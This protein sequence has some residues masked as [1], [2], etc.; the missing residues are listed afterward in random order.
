MNANPLTQAIES[1]V[2]DCNDLSCDGICNLGPIAG[3]DR[4]EWLARLKAQFIAHP[5]PT[6]TK[7]RPSQQPAVIRVRAQTGSLLTD[8]NRCG[9]PRWNGKACQSCR[10]STRLR[11]ATA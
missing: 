3:E 1:A 10:A 2:L 11:R 8:C 5:I 7:G 9:E 4:A 6:S